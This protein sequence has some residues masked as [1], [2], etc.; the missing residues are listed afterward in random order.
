MHVR[1]LGV[2]LSGEGF[3]RR[4]KASRETTHGTG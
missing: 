1:R 3:K 4:N 2:V